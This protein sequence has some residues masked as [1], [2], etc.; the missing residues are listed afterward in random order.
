MR[1]RPLHADL[2]A[3]VFGF[4]LQTGGSPEEVEALRQA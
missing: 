2:G 3:E 4:D 1:F